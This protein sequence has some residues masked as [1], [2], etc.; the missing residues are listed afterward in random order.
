[1]NLDKK[2]RAFAVEA[3]GDQSYGVEP[4]SVHLD[5]VHAL[6]VA[7]GAPPDVCVA[8]FC[9]DCVEDTAV[10][11]A[12]VRELFGESVAGLVAAVTN[13]PGKNRKER[14]ARTYPKIRQAGPDAVML[15][16]CDR[17][18]NVEAVSTPK[19]DSKIAMYQKEHEAFRAALYVAGEHESVWARLEAALKAR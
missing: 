9:H 15:K 14:N 7:F 5:A 1:M 6:A 4:Y 12:Q 13:E 16:L 19:A 3:H 10:T 11:I 18:A 8:A 17:I 2:A